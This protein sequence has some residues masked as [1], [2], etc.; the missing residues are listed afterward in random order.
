MGASQTHALPPLSDAQR[1]AIYGSNILG[2]PLQPCTRPGLDPVTGANRDGYAAYL[3]SDPGCHVVA[4]EVT[5][6]FLDFT[7]S[8][9]NNLSDPPLIVQWLCSFPGLRPGNRWALC[10]SRWR[11]AWTMGVA[12]PIVAA[13]THEHTLRFVSKEVLLDHAL[14]VPGYPMYMGQAGVSTLAGG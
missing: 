7:K 9:G 4:A 2:G 13:A 8:R 5:Q 14:D 10:A 12:P 3:P 6:A 1:H 11:E